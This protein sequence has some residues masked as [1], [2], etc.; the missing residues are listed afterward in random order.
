MR[1]LLFEKVF[2]TSEG[3]TT[4]ILLQYVDELMRKGEGCEFFVEGGR[5][6][7]GKALYPKGGLLS[8]VVDS[9]IEGKNAQ[10]T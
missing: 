10:I 4:M 1:H 6:R 3:K 5:T 7:S 9:Y 2:E 8:V